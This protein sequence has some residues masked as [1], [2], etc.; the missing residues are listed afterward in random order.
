M[1]VGTAALI[2]LTGPTQDEWQSR[3][4]SPSRAEVVMR[5]SLQR[6]LASPKSGL[7][8]GIESSER[9]GL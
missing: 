5:E 6:N 8:A 3:A 2:A 9:R 4:N 1:I 7:W